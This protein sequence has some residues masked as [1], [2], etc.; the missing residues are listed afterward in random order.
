[1]EAKMMAFTLRMNL[2][3]PL[4]RGLKVTHT[5]IPTGVISPDYS[6]LLI[7]GIITNSQVSAAVI[8]CVPTA[9]IYHFVPRA[10]RHNVVKPRC[11][12]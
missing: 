9:M 6:I 12:S 8:K 7:S 10:Q 11:A 5:F 4:S 1:M 2:R 3:V